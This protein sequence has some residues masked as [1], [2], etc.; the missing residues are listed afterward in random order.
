MAAKQPAMRPTGETVEQV[1]A[2]AHGPRRAE[3][4]E[5]CALMKDISGEPPKVWAS[6]IV[7]FG[8]VTYRYE[9]GHGGTMPV[10]AFSPTASRHTIYLTSDFEERWPELVSQLG[11]HTSGTSCLYL[12]R[13]SNVDTSV[14]RRLLERTR[15]HALSEWSNT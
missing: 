6:R 1:L 8:E 12:T 11:R 14:L 3:A 13:L 9:S 15:D 5:L 4:D 2:R 7:G 10:L